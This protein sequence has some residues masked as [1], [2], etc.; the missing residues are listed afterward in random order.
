M[1]YVKTINGKAVKDEEA[2]EKIQTLEDGIV[3]EQ[4]GKS[5]EVRSIDVYFATNAI[6]LNGSDGEETLF[7]KGTKIYNTSKNI[8]CELTNNSFYDIFDS[9]VLYIPSELKGSFAVGD[10]VSITPAEVTKVNGSPI[11]DIVA[12]ERIATLETASAEHAE[13][14]ATLE[15]KPY[16][17]QYVHCITIK[18]AEGATRVIDVVSNYGDAPFTISEL[19]NVLTLGSVTINGKRAFV[20]AAHAYGGFS[21]PSVKI[22]HYG[23]MSPYGK[24]TNVILRYDDNH[25][26]I[27]DMEEF[28]PTEYTCNVLRLKY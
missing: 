28:E 8:E 4:T 5:W 27:L 11:K 3:K 10:L 1:E 15:A 13:K 21:Y 23:T 7:Q 2:R 20:Y 18:N 14:I 22:Y 26:P 24:F 19:N 25:K 6:S 17:V 9:L 16:T 12:R